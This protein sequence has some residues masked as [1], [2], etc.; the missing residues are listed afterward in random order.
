VGNIIFFS[1]PSWPIFSLS[2]LFAFFA[3]LLT[4]EDPPHHPTTAP[5]FRPSLCVQFTIYLPMSN[6]KE[7]KKDAIA[8]LNAEHEEL[9]GTYIQETKPTSERRMVYIINALILSIA[10]VCMCSFTPLSHHFLEILSTFYL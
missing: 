6:K 1:A 3:A 5:S 7:R 2:S 4:C 10:P 8:A 9:F